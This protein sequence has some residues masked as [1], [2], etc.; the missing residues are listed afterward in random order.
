MFEVQKAKLKEAPT[1]LVTSWI[2]HS[3]D[4]FAEA[5][6]IVSVENNL[7]SKVLNSNGVEKEK[8]TSCAK[9]S[10]IVPE[11]VQNHI[12]NG[13]PNVIIQPLPSKRSET[14]GEIKSGADAIVK[15]HKVEAEYFPLANT[16]AKHSCQSFKK[17]RRVGILPRLPKQRVEELIGEIVNGNQENKRGSHRATINNKIQQELAKRELSIEEIVRKGQISTTCIVSS[18]NR[19]R[20]CLKIVKNFNVGC[21]LTKNSIEEQKKLSISLKHVNLLRTI[22]VDKTL[23]DHTLFLTEFCNCG[24]MC[25]DIRMNGA[26][27]DSAIHRLFPQI[28]AA[29]SYLHRNGIVHGSICCDNI[30]LNYAHNFDNATVKL[31]N[32]TTATSFGKNSTRVKRRTAFSG[33]SE[34]MSPAIMGQMPHDLRCTDVWSLGCVLFLMKVAVFPFGKFSGDRNEFIGVQKSRAF[35]EMIKQS[36]IYVCHDL[37]DLFHRLFQFNESERIQLNDICYHDWFTNVIENTQ[38]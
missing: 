14:S 7:N 26:Y 17:I 10:N 31:C 38:L 30:L 28:V 12:S 35:V 22:I 3:K 19:E 8:S 2:D 5:N 4:I 32:F 6:N 20:M 23:T 13:K 21:N 9:V 15:K 18:A 37:L 33:S 25:H 1:V 36:G 34:Y 16:A 24:D 27:L 29:V 11:K